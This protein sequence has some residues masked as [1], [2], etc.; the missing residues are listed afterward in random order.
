M[1]EPGRPGQRTKQAAQLAVPSLPLLEADSLMLGM[2]VAMAFE[3]PA[4]DTSVSLEH[5]TSCRSAL[6]TDKLAADLAQLPSADPVAVLRIALGPI[7]Q[8]ASDLLLCKLGTL[9]AKAA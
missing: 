4:A 6:E 5:D 1:A 8:Q 3:L 7:T 9:L 2:V